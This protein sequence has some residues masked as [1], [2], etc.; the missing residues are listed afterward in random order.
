MKVYSWLGIA[1]WQCKQTYMGIAIKVLNTLIPPGS[2]FASS[3]KCLQGAIECSL[4][5]WNVV[6]D[7]NGFVFFSAK[8]ISDSINC[9]KHLL[10]KLIGWG[11]T[12][13]LYFL[14]CHNMT[15]K[16]ILLT[17]LSL[18][19]FTT[20]ICTSW[21]RVLQMLPFEKTF[22]KQRCRIMTSNTLW[23]CNRVQTLDQ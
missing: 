7:P 15:K 14:L 12:L 8:S 20:H 18:P 16:C 23:P 2:S 3:K 1:K 17:N 11:S 9:I 6:T 22:L 10:D 21:F 5:L 4:I 13:Y 19:G